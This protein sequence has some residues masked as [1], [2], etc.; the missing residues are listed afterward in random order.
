MEFRL[1]SKCDTILLINDTSGA[2]HHDDDSNG[3]LN[4][5]IRLPKARDGIYDIWAGTL[6]ADTCDATL[7]IETF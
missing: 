4:A 1:D 7:T 6:S 3:N 2:W 5:K